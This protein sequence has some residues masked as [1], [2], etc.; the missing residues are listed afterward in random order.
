MEVNWIHHRRITPLWPQANS[1]VESF[2][3]PLLKAIQTAHAEGR[4]WR[5]ELQK[6]LMNLRST[7][8]TTTDVSPAELL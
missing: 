5:R 4:N 2:M 8:H 7:P 6:F 3:K 1:E